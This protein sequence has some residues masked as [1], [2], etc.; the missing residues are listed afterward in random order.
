MFTQTQQIEQDIFH[1]EFN[2]TTIRQLA[3]NHANILHESL[4][5]NT[6]HELQT[7]LSD[8]SLYTVAFNLNSCFMIAMDYV[9]FAFLQ[10]AEDD[11]T[12]CYYIEQ[13]HLCLAKL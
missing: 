7:N 3:Q 11:Q 9:P 8:C 1:S 12:L 13:I 10:I 5:D 6:L 2:K 4:L